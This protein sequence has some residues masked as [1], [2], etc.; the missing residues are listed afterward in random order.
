VCVKEEETILQWRFVPHD[1]TFAAAFQ[2]GLM[3]FS[4]R[5]AFDQVLVHMQQNVLMS[6]CVS[7]AP[8]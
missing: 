4:I 8:T 2:L 6:D 3:T 7:T 1:I 5:R